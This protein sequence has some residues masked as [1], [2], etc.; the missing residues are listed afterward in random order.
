[1]KVWAIK[2]D[3]GSEMASLPGK[4]VEAH[5]HIG[6]Q[7]PRRLGITNEYAIV[8]F[9]VTG[10][11]IGVVQSGGFI[12]T[13]AMVTG[14]TVAPYAMTGI[15]TYFVSDV[16]AGHAT[17]GDK[18][19]A[20]S[21]LSTSGDITGVRPFYIAF[22]DKDLTGPQRLEMGL[23]SSIQIV[24]TTYTA[25]SFTKSLHE[26]YKANQQLKLR[27]HLNKI[28]DVPPTGIEKFDELAVNYKHFEKIVEG[29]EKRG[30]K[31]IKD[32]TLDEVFADVDGK[33]KIFTYNPETLTKLG[34]RHEL[35]H[36]RQLKNLEKSG[37][38]YHSGLENYFERG[39]YLME[40]DLG[41]KFGFSENYMNSIEYYLKVHQYTSKESKF[42][43]YNEKYR[44]VKK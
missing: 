9:K 15:A 5:T 30:F 4:I 28:D 22:T 37:L 29:M 24:A 7:L 16:F 35:H 39:A 8:P 19:I 3:V 31:V 41:I 40:K 43:R 36:F 14:Q 38:K 20:S 1:M 10:T 11:V 6:D 27:T 32:T 21:L 34:L 44:G 2:G 42:F 33:A 23:T 12:A 18:G 17:E 13:Q 25:H 26:T